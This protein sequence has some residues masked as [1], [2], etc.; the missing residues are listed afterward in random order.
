MEPAREIVGANKVLNVDKKLRLQLYYPPSRARVASSMHVYEWWLKHPRNRYPSTLYVTVKGL[1][2]PDN[3]YPNCSMAAQLESGILQSDL[4]NDVPVMENNSSDAILNKEPLKWTRL[5]GQACHI[6]NR[7]LLSLQG[8]HMGC[9]SLRF[10]HVGRTLAAACADRDGYPIRSSSA[11]TLRSEG[12][13]TW[14]VRALCKNVCA[15]GAEDG[16]ASE[17]GKQKQM[18]QVSV[19]SI[20]WGHNQ[21]LCSIIWGKCVYGASY[22]VIINLYAGLYE[23]YFNMEHFMGPIMN[24]MERYMGLLIQYGYSKT[25]NLLM[26]QLILLLL[27]SNFTFEIYR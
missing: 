4:Q 18:G 15:E 12:A 27:V 20:L 7:H 5:P 16:A 25:L 1:K 14:L 13:V 22:G 17:R 6:P 23:A 10:S 9:F 24:S 8:G 26:S 11:V 2:L 21:H 3:V 19:W